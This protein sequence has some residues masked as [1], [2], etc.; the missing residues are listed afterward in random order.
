MKTPFGWKWSWIAIAAAS[1]LLVFVLLL[2]LIEMK[3]NDPGP[4]AQ[5]AFQRYIRNPIPRSVTDLRIHYSPHMRGYWMYLVFHIDPGDLDSL[6][7]L[8]Q[9]DGDV[10]YGVTNGVM[11]FPGWTDG[12][13]KLDPDGFMRMMTNSSMSSQA[14]FG[15]ASQWNCNIVV[16]GDHRKV[17]WYLS[18]IGRVQTK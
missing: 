6:F 17:Y 16:S 11:E 12:F 9:F 13:R 5:E 3:T 14:E 18:P 8:R 15:Q 7:D 10:P 2:V 4:S 1:P